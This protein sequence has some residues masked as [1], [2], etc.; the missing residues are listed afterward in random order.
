MK[1]SIVTIT[2]NN[3]LELKTT[4][5][6]ISGIPNTES[7]IINGGRCQET[8]SFLKD[9]QELVGLSEADEGISDAFNK[10]IGL[11][12]G[13]AICFLNS[14]DKLTDRTY[15]DF[16][17]DQFSKNPDIDFI[18]ADIIFNHRDH[19]ELLVKPNRSLGKTP[20]PHPSLIVRKKVFD[21]VGGFDKNL[22][23]AM[24]FDFMCKMINKNYKGLYYDKG[25]V[26]FM[27]GNGASSSNGLKGINERLLVLKRYG[28]LDFHSSFYLK[29]LKLKMKIRIIL[30]KISLLESYDKLKKYFFTPKSE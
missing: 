29:K 8:A 21:D 25:P 27:D 18:Y 23:I 20:F 7:V 4:L 3:F 19:G 6:T 13:D 1:L 16:A 12:T 30:Q 26:V 24:D 9:H 11:T 17:I 22:K 28:L 10:G 15:Y 5:E 14:G 2:Y